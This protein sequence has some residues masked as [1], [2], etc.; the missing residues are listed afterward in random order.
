VPRQNEGA[1]GSLVFGVRPEHVRLADDGAYRGR[2]RAVEYLGTTQ[3][4]TIDTPNGPL[5]ARTPAGQ[6]ARV[7]EVVGLGF[8]APTVT[9]FEAATGRALRS[10][11]NE[12]AAH[13]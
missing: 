7:D 5:K 13:G 6:P 11:L 3:I 1:R 9:L 8:A 12:G 2:I 10:A 4:V